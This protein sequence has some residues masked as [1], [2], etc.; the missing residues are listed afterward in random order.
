MREIILSG[1]LFH[2]EGGGSSKGL[3]ERGVHVDLSYWEVDNWGEPERASHRR[4]RRARFLYIILIMVRPSQR[5]PPY[6]QHTGLAACNH[7]T[8]SRTKKEV[9]PTHKKFRV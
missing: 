3:T 4:E 7:C 8:T 6:I 5:A 2:T 9:E 1:R